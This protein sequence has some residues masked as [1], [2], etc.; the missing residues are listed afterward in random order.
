MYSLAFQ[1]YITLVIDD[2][3]IIY[4]HIIKTHVGEKCSCR[5]TYMSILHPNDAAFEATKQ[6]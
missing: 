6:L 5:P 2:F 3:G 4:I 1:Y